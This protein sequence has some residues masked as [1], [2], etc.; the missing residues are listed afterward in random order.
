MAKTLEGTVTG[1]FPAELANKL[2][3]AIAS[4]IRCGMDPDVACSIAAAVVGDY[5]RGHY[6]DQYLVAMARL[7]MSRAGQPFPGQ[8]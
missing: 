4:A 6:G 2:S 7:V 3:D 1:P 8:A 5:A